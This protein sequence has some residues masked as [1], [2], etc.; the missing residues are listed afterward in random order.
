MIF[1]V[2]PRGQRSV[3]QDVKNVYIYIIVFDS[4]TYVVIHIMDYGINV[5]GSIQILFFHIHLI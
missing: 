4:F 5:M 1:G 2:H 3:E